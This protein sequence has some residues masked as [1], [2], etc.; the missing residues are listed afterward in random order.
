M[1]VLITLHDAGGTVPPV[2]AL[3]EALVARG[4]DATVL[5]QPSVRARAE[6]AGATFEPLSSLGD[7]DHRRPIEE[8]L[9]LVG[10]AIV[11][12]GVGDDLVRAAA[13]ADVLVVD[14]NLAGAL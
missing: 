4:H 14:A 9:E 1:R 11:G 8:Q 6:V 13:D 5:G 12:R 3:V 10:P 7:Y 2:I